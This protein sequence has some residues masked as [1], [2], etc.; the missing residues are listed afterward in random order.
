MKA[1]GVQRC[2]RATGERVTLELGPTEERE[3]CSRKGKAGPLKEKAGRDGCRA[4]E[5]SG[6]GGPGRC[7]GY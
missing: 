4:M 5:G 6:V 3:V 1:C 2:L 7:L